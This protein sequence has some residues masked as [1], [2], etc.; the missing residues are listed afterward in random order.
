MTTSPVSL[1]ASSPV[2][3]GMLNEKWQRRFLALAKMW[4]ET[5]SK[6]PSKKVGAVIVDGKRRV[7][8]MGYNGFPRG[9]DD[10]AGRYDDKDIKNRMAV[11][12]E[13]N[14]ILNAVKSV[15]GGTLF[16]WPL[17]TCHECAKL[18]IQSGI[19]RVVGPRAKPDSSWLDSQTLALQMYGE[20]GVAVEFWEGEL[21]DAAGRA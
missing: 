17:F 13:A 14:A 20:A 12:A 3:E 21:D 5:C 16:V 7:I 11:H 9:V 19:R 10:L 2:E 18:V 8:A 1:R 4:G 15:E 6:D